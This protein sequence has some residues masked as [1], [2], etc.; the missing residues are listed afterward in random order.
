VTLDNPA[1][2][3]NFGS[4]VAIA[5]STIVVGADGI[6]GTND[7]G[8]AAYV[9]TKGTGAWST[10]P[11]VSLGDPGA[12][13]NGGFG[14]A[15]ALSGGSIAVGAPFE[16]GS[17][18]QPGSGATYLYVV[19]HGS[20]PSRPTKT[21]ADPNPQAGDDYGRAVAIS[22]GTLVVGAD[23]RE[24][25]MAPPGS[26]Y[27]Y[28]ADRRAWPSL[29]SVTLTDPRSTSADGFGS[30]VALDRGTLSVGAM[31]ALDPSYDG[32]AYVFVRQGTRWSTTPTAVL[33]REDDGPLQHYFGAAVATS[34][35]AVVVGAPAGYAG[36]SA[37]Y[38][39]FISNG[40]WPTI[41]TVLTGN[42]ANPLVPVYDDYGS[43]VALSG[44][45][46]AVGAWEANT[47][48]GAVYLYS[49]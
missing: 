5:G 18:V 35:T 1:D 7:S 47:F 45:I 38:S 34:Q 17:Q 11:A 41:P 6:S 39:Y 24:E 43:A 2:V 46:V 29:P 20:W 10:T 23:G 8:G 4:S 13:I 32:L 44:N 14:F 28:R 42:P 30:A 25:T 9:Y 21:L 16:R 48:N 26:A 27:V 37:I 22:D 31:G 40:E 15:V 19:R 3:F 36:P 12:S 49:L 33:G